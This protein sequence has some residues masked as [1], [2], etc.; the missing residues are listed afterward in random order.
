MTES[1]QAMVARTLAAFGRL[2]A[3]VCSAAMDPKFDNEHA[4]Q[5]RNTFEDYPLEAWRQFAWMANCFPQARFIL[6]TRR[7]RALFLD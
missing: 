3:L 6:T 5:H 7:L 4:G 1:V 2:D